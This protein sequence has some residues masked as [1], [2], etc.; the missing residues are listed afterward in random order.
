[1]Q[2]LKFE[3][4]KH[5]PGIHLNPDTNVFEFWGFSLPEDSISFYTPVFNWFNEWKNNIPQ[6]I[7]QSE[8]VSLVFK[9]T[10]FNSSSF[11]AILEILLLFS[12]YQGL[13]LAVNVD[14]HYE[15]EDTQFYE[16][17]KELSEITHIP[18]NYVEI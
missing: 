16:N 18:F 17:G 9:F 10:Y 8:K 12:K 5:K 14:W 6:L 1:M 11:R 13:G 15:K 2:A 4:T 7:A 3:A